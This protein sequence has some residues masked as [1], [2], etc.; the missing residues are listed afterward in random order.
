[1]IV[2][3]TA[4]PIPSGIRFLLHI[5]LESSFVIFQIV[6]T[7]VSVLH[8]TLYTVSCIYM[9]YIYISCIYMIYIYHA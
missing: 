8:V 9:I 5:Y 3:Y 1:M 6:T 4:R 2:G 7:L